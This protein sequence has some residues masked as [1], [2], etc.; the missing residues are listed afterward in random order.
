MGLIFNTSCNFK[1]FHCKFFQKSFHSYSFWLQNFLAL[2]F[3]VFNGLCFAY[4]IRLVLAESQTN[5]K[6]LFTFILNLE[7]GK[8]LVVVITLL[9][10]YLFAIKFSLSRKWAVWSISSIAFFCSV[11]LCIQHLR[12]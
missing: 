10:I 11:Y 12:F 7:V 4:S 9:L 8:A 1:Y 6:A 5:K 2:V 3:G